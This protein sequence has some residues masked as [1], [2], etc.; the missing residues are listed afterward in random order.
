VGPPLLIG[1]R[2]KTVTDQNYRLEM[3]DISKAFPGVQALSN[4]SFNLRPGEIHALVGENGAGK[5]TL[6]KIL[7]GAYQRDSGTIRM[8]GDDVEISNPSHALALGIITI[9]QETSLCGELSVAENIFMGRLPRSGPF[10]QWQG[11]YDDAQ[12][13]LDQL[14]T[15]FDARS[16][17]G[18]LSTAQRQM[19]EIARALSMNARVIV[20]DEPTASLTDSEVEVLFDTIRRLRSGGVSII[21]ISH[22][23]SEIFAL[24]DR[25]TVLRDGVWVSTAETGTTDEATIVRHMV[26]RNVDDLF[27]RQ[28]E[29]ADTEPVLTVAGLTG[30]KFFDISFEVHAGEIV[31]LFGLVGSGRTDLVRAL[32]GAETIYSGGIHIDGE[33]VAPHSPRDAIRSGVVLAPEDR[34]EHGL[35]LG[36]TVQE[37][38]TLPNLKRVS[39]FGF[40]RPRYERE[41]AGRYR[42]ELAI[43]T[44]TLA[45]QA[46]SLSGGN[47]QKVVLAK[48]LARKP[49]VLILDEPTRGI[50][51]AGKAEVHRLMNSLA[52]QGVAVLMVSS[53]LPEILGMSDRVLIMHEKRLAGE[54]TRADATEERIMAYATG[55]MKREKETAG[56]A[57]AAS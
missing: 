25:V 43:R 54:L 40:L 42:D 22:R 56:E 20:F 51:V 44:P 47:Q 13:L 41:L 9:Y 6:I 33:P 2:G 21:Y 29:H 10:V 17:L 19:V 37:N 48:W 45:T 50:D 4:I 28:G 27:S 49:K 12:K 32:F 55:Q 24:S 15:P 57:H 26:G 1:K 14:E 38:V 34:K 11:L 23:L 5:S 16:R 30:R 36:M 35:V 8:D 3:V 52:E 39:E 46:A 31:G 53:E 7:S 18:D